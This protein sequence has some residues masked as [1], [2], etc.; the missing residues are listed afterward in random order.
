MKSP[1][2]IIRTLIINSPH[3]NNYRSSN[4]TK[5]L[6]PKMYLVTYW[7]TTTTCPHTETQ[8]MCTGKITLKDMREDP[9]T[10]LIYLIAQSSK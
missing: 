8:A 9:M 1:S 2:N 3:Q 7:K 10:C 5:T 4:S 6:S